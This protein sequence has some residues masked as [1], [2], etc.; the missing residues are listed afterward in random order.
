MHFTL[1]KDKFQ[2][3]CHII[4]EQ[5]WHHKID[6]GGIGSKLPLFV[7]KSFIL[8]PTPISFLRLFQFPLPLLSRLV[9]MISRILFSKLLVYK[10][11]W[12]YFL[13]FHLLGS[14]RSLDEEEVIWIKP[15][16]KNVKSHKIQNTGYLKKKFGPKNHNQNRVLWDQIL[17]W[18]SLRSALVLGRMTKKIRIV[19]E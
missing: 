3:S 17:P 18:I 14:F 11:P 5:V 6:F 15:K 1:H 16:S 7:L 19:T 4:V 2:L 12:I 13:F 9:L 8:S 10:S